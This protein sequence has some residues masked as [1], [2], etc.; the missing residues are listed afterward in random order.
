MSYKD[1]LVAASLGLPYPARSASVLGHLI[2]KHASW[3]SDVNEERRLALLRLL[4]T[5]PIDWRDSMR[6]EQYPDLLG[7]VPGCLHRAHVNVHSPRFSPSAPIRL[8]TLYSI[9]P[10]VGINHMCV[11]ND[12]Q[13]NTAYYIAIQDKLSAAHAKTPMAGVKGV[14]MGFARGYERWNVVACFVQRLELQACA[15][16]CVN[17]LVTNRD[18]RSTALSHLEK[19]S[20]KYDVSRWAWAREEAARSQD[21]QDGRKGGGEGG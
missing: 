13:T 11:L 16:M 15:N 8:N 21:R 2:S 9:G 10:D 3:A 7:A 1:L 17:V 20:T 12:P 5:T 6:E 18:I 4:E 19:T 14:V